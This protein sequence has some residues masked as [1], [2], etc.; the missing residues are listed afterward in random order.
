MR[1][2]CSAALALSVLTTPLQAEDSKVV[3]T[4]W[5]LFTDHCTQYLEAETIPDVL[6]AFAPY[7]T[8]V[9]TTSDGA[10]Q[11][12]RSFLDDLPGSSEV[13][14]SLNFETNRIEGGTFYRCSF[15][16]HLQE[17]E[18]KNL[19]QFAQENGPDL[20]GETFNV[21]GGTFNVN[22]EFQAD[23]AA[24][25]GESI[26]SQHPGSRLKRRLTSRGP[27]NTLRSACQ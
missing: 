20:L 4:V 16:F 7:D 13:I 23:A 15:L 18:L 3:E 26:P 17:D 19:P 21:N 11:M 14:F 22:S 27:R 1:F 5:K 9:R 24:L 10:L 2:V 6:A 25:E 8:Y 12:G